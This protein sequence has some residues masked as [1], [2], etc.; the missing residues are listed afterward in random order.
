MKCAQNTPCALGTSA[1]N[2]PRREMGA[3]S[4][5]PLRQRWAGRISTKFS[6]LYAVVSC[7][8]WASYEIFKKCLIFCAWKAIIRRIHNDDR[9]SVRFYTLTD[10][11]GHTPKCDFSGRV[12]TEPTAQESQLAETNPQEVTHVQVAH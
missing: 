4:A 6:S 3:R 10:S 7:A 5:R 9:S 2:L 11:E 1:P 8:T 12:G